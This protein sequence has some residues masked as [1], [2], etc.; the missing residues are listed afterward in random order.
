[1]SRLLAKQAGGEFPRDQRREFIGLRGQV[2]E[3]IE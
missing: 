3:V 1:M 2:D